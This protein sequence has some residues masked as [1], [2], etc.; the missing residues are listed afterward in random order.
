MYAVPVEIFLSI[1]LLVRPQSPVFRKHL[2]HYCVLQWKY[3]GK[4]LYSYPVFLQGGSTYCERWNRLHQR[5]ARTA[6]ARGGGG[7]GE[8]AGVKLGGDSGD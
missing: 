2:N 1:P 4:E 6:T 8:A 3:F 7:G 5:A